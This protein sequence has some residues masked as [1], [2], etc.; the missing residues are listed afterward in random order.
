[1]T[2]VVSSFDA[3]VNADT[4]VLVVGSMPGT[5]SLE[6]VQYYAH[7]RNAFWPIMSHLFEFDAEL[8]YTERCE[9]LQRNGVG[10]WDTLRACVRPGSLDSAIV[11][12]SIE[13]ND[14]AGLLREYPSIQAIFFNGAKS[15]QV[16]KRHVLPL[17]ASSVF[18]GFDEIT[19]GR[20]PSTSPAN[21]GT[22]F[23]DKLAAWQV[24]RAAIHPCR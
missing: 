22:S 23:A 4:Q 13:A 12:S 16:F 2:E 17:L 3:I 11:E 18:A 1:M 20:L 19:R 8:P 7:P 21:A 15:E 24:V 10:L 14:F 5:A 9:I 6:A